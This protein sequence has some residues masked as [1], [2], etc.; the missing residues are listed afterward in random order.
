MKTRTAVA[1]V[2]ASALAIGG[3]SLPAVA[4]PDK[5]IDINVALKADITPA[6]LKALG[7]YGKVTGQL[8][9]IDAVTLKA[10][11]SALP[12]IQALD[13]VA[14]ANPDAKRIGKPGTRTRQPSSSWMRMRSASLASGSPCTT[15]VWRGGWCRPRIQAISSSE[16]A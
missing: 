3:A 9:Q 11:S 10:R 6:A 7:A 1:L 16:S 4:A 2:A 13:I 15:R 5:N 8:P 14:A 12:K